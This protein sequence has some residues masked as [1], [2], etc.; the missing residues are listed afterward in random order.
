[1]EIDSID[2]IT[3]IHSHKPNLYA[4]LQNTLPVGSQGISDSRKLTPVKTDDPQKAWAQAVGLAASSVNS[5]T[6]VPFPYLSTTITVK[7]NRIRVWFNVSANQSA[8]YSVYTP[9]VNGAAIPYAYT[10]VAFNA[11]AAVAA[12]A[13][14]SY[15]VSVAP[16][17]HKI[18]LYVRTNSQTMT[19]PIS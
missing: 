6:N 12:T 2:I 17:T 9:Y 13:S 14:A 18:D 19:I 7:S 11:G 5:S 15:I 8:S 10:T 16:G 1:M 3:P 4:D